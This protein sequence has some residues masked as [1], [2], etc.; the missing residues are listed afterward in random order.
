MISFFMSATIW[1]E[2]A[3]DWNDRCTGRRLCVLSILCIQL[4]AEWIFFF[5]C[6]NIFA[7]VFSRWFCTEW[8]MCTKCLCVWKWTME[9]MLMVTNEWANVCDDSYKHRKWNNKNTR[10]TFDQ[11][12]YSVFIRFDWKYKLNWAEKMNSL[13]SLRCWYTHA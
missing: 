11:P 10:F 9:M 8:M 5:V 2:I 7:F 6:R 4:N 12:P 13:M 3:W 1:I